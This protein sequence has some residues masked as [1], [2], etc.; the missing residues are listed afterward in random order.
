MATETRIHKYEAMFVFPQ[1]YSADLNGA[2]D[3][4]KEI[5]SKGSAD[6]TSM[7]K[8]DERRLAY[9]IKGNKRGVYFLCRFHCDAT[10]VKEIERDCRLSEKLLRSLITRND[11][12]TEEQMRNAE[13]AQKTADEARLRAMDEEDMGVRADV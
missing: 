7:V 3:H 13:A 11:E 9:D 1:S 5:L 2:M 12:L 10:K 6:V 8:W 4:I